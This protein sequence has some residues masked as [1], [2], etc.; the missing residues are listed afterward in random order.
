M[1]TYLFAVGRVLFFAFGLFAASSVYGQL[2]STSLV[3]TQDAYIRSQTPS[4]NY[5][6][7][8]SMRVS[9][10]SSAGIYRSAIKFDLSSIPVGAKIVSAQLRLK[11]GLAL[12]SGSYTTHKLSRFT[13]SSIWT[14]TGITSANQ[15]SIESGG[16]TTSTSDGVYRSFNVLADVV[17]M[18]DG[19][20]PNNGWLLNLTNETTPFTTNVDFGTREVSTAAHKPTLIIT[21]YLPVKITAATVTH[22]STLASTDGSITP[23]I[24]G[25]S[26]NYTYQW[27]NGSTGG[28][29][30][31]TASLSGVGDGWY[32]LRITDN[33]A[34][35]V[36]YMAFIVGVKCGKTMIDF[37][38]GPDYVD[39]ALILDHVL[40]GVNKG[41]T[42]DGGTSE[43]TAA[44]LESPRTNWY[45]TKSLLRFRL[46]VDPSVSIDM[47][48]L[49][50]TG[51]IHN[52]SSRPNTSELSLIS[53]TWE[54][55]TVRYVN[56][57]TYSTTSLQVLHGTTTSNENKV[58]KLASFWNTWKA[59]NT[60]NFGLMFQLQSLANSATTMQFFSSDVTTATNRPWIRFELNLE[61]V[62]GCPSAVPTWNAQAES[63]E[64][65]V[66]ITS[67]AGQ[68]SPYQYHISTQPIAELIETYRYI[69]DSLGFEIDST[70]FFQGKE[71]AQTFEFSGLDAGRYYVSVFNNSGQ[72]I[73]NRTKHVQGTLS[74]EQQS[75]LVI[76]GNRITATSA[77]GAGSL[78]LYISEIT[79]AS[80]F[81]T[82]LESITASGEQFVGLANST[83]TVTS[84]TGLAFGFRVQGNTLFTVKNGAVTSVPG[85]LVSGD[86]LKI[87]QVGNSLTLIK[88]GTTLLTET[89]PTTFAYKLG[90]GTQFGAPLLVEILGPSS[91][92]KPFVFYPTVTSHLTCDEG[93]GSFSFSVN[94]LGTLNGE[95]IS[96]SIV[97]AV[98][99]QVV[100]A[101]GT[102][103]DAQ[104]ITPLNQYANGDP[105][106]AGTYT[107]NFNVGSLSG[108]GQISLGYEA[109]WA[110]SD[111][112]YTYVPNSYSLL[113]N[114]HDELTYVQARSTNIMRYDVEG[115]IEFTPVVANMGGANIIRPTTLNL[116]DPPSLSLLNEELTAFSKQNA[117]NNYYRIWPFTPAQGF[118]GNTIIANDNSRVKM[119]FTTTGG[120]GNGQIMTYVNGVLK[121]TMNRGNSSIIARFNSMKNNDGFKDV[122][123]S[124]PCPTPSDLYGHLKYTLDGFHHTMKNGKI[125]FV[126]DQEYDTDNLTF[127]IYN[128]NDVLV[129]TQSHF[130]PIQTTNGDNY[131]TIDVSDNTHCIGRG[132]F[133]LEVINSKKEKMYLRFFNDF[134]NPNCLDYINANQGS[135]N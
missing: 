78:K 95:T 86:V 119:V 87:N 48:D 120:A 98:T 93:V 104:G 106:S 33:T 26:N 96:Y 1:N 11:P 117:F 23:T 109:D 126:F 123:T 63:G 12:S 75:G 113:V 130:S 45:N 69:K 19:A 65:D 73:V 17:G 50:L 81:E 101:N 30:A 80:G 97:N 127:N 114:G 14:E 76:T 55:S 56:A 28:V 91:L 40:T 131:L 53:S 38:P 64:I 105:L 62:S 103:G 132:F 134:T 49:Y 121:S 128:Q 8:T 99:N 107:V 5:G 16:I 58:V 39:D 61:D 60:T 90:V 41:F 6:T 42:N 100:I 32:G 88:N 67:L 21:Y 116:N 2:S 31:S 57:P 129:K 25:G 43:F 85:T 35:I 9:Y 94:L 82:V 124:F 92:W 22:A 110:Q 77:N 102:I 125:R 133:Y 108:V 89:L 71:T 51:N 7:A 111:P 66:N 135:N 3:A 112:E 46:W 20:Y 4:T 34:S 29:I 54:E 74:F 122:I 115:W 47:A 84:Y 27:I 59:N 18:L 72:R 83:T 68:G 44:K 24:T 13:T 70:Q 36:T 37:K 118:Y 52:P 10:S 79:N 15:P